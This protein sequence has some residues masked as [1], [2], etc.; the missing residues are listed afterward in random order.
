MWTVTDLDVLP[1]ASTAWPTKVACEVDGTVTS[2]GQDAMPEVTSRQG[3]STVTWAGP[4]GT[5]TTERVGAVPSIATSTLA[6][7]DSPAMSVTVPVV[8]RWAP[9]PVRVVPAEQ[10]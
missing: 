5:T 10:V 4:S 6:F 9:S 1:A 8:V 3:Q 2:A 7:A